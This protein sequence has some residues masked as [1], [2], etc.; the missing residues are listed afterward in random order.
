MST[1][2]TD[3]VTQE[4]PPRAP[5]LRRKTDDGMNLPVGKTCADCAHC[6]RCCAIFGH[7]PGDEVCDFYPSRFL[8]RHP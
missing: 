7:I 6:R 5:M 8:E 4:R 3:G 1:Q 2:A